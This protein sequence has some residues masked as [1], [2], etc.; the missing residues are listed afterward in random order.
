MGFENPSFIILQGDGPPLICVTSR[1][2]F[3]TKVKR[4]WLNPHAYDL[5]VQLSIYKPT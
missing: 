1:H 2:T 3:L 4:V 5:V